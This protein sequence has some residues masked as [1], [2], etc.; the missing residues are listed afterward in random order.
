MDKVVVKSNG[1]FRGSK[2]LSGCWTENGSLGGSGE[3]WA[4]LAEM[5]RAE[6]S[7]NTC[8]GRTLG[9]VSGPD[10]DAVR[11]SWGCQTKVPPT[12]A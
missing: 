5:D 8:G 9:L 7:L 6:V 2:R 11:V 1:K 12:R 10:A 4:A 3:G